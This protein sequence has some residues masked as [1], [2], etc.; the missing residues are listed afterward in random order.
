MKKLYL[1]PILHM[2][3][4]MGSLA[5][6]LDETAKAEFGQEVWQKHKG[7][8]SSFW[9]SI[10]QFFDAMDVKESLY[11]NGAN[12]LTSCIDVTSVSQGEMLY[13]CL[14]VDNGCTSFCCPFC[15]TIAECD[16]CYDCRNIRNCFGCVNVVNGQ[17]LWFNQQL[18]KEDY[19]QRRK[20]FWAQPNFIELAKAERNKLILSLP[21]RYADIKFCE[22]CTG[23]YLYHSNNA[24]DCYESGELE[25]TISCHDSRKAINSAYSGNLIF[26]PGFV[27]ECQNIVGGATASA[28]CYLCADGLSN[29]YYSTECYGCDTIFGCVGLKRKKFTILNKQYEQPE[30][31]ALLPKIIAH[32]TETGEW[33]KFLPTYVSAF[34]YNESAAS[35]YFPLTEH[36]AGDMGFNWSDYAPPLPKV[37]KLLTRDM[38]AQMP[39]APQMTDELVNW[40][41]ECAET[42][43]PFQIMPMELAFYRAHNLPIPTLHPKQ[44]LQH[45]LN[46]KNRRHLFDRACSK[47]GTHVKTTFAQTRAEKIVCE[48]CYL[49]YQGT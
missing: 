5:S 42:G 3:A 37:E 13:Q 17:Y 25:H 4:D 44:R 33:G 36:Q 31:E 47:C 40:A 30:Y 35:L 21:H 43:K 10:G 14:M 23:N 6:A 39:R 48:P 27:Y 15:H 28:F 7:A 18:T 22:D 16:F 11:A 34:G 32:M 8:V 24:H 12:N 20:A 1:V 38:H 46:Q 19:D 29:A 41:I 49:A 9:D 26:G 2:S 45:R